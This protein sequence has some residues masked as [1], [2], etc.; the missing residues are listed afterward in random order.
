M[1]E[2]RSVARIRERGASALEIRLFV[3]LVAALDRARDAERLWRVAADLYERASWVFDP[4]QLAERPATDV[5]N[6]LAETGVS[7]RHGP[8]SSAWMRISEALIHPSSPDSVKRAIWDAEV[9][10]R[11]LLRDVRESA[12]DGRNW[13]PLLRGPKIS[14]MW[15]RMLVAPGDAHAEHLKA[16]PVAVDVHVR[17][18]TQNLGVLDTH[19]L[20]LETARPRIQAVWDS[21]AH[22]AAGP[23]QL[24]GTA[25][26]ID[27]A[28][29]F[30]GKWGCSYC[31]SAGRQV[32]VS[33][34][35]SGCTMG[36]APVGP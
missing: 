25:A 29:W 4:A 31:E 14:V 30:L 15:I 1:P 8:D 3:T 27:P 35:C 16:L 26:A 28:L 36:R 20:S 10:A 9:D 22:A 7:Q 32:P 34:L 24:A 18:V 12:F 17:R 13:F 23:G 21:V 11:A 2:F 5:R 6:L 19:D 33:E